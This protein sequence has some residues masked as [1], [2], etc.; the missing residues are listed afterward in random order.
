M[1]TKEF[2]DNYK[3]LMGEKIWGDVLVDIEEKIREKEE[4]SQGG[5]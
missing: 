3:K 4:T 2:G 5:R 1:M